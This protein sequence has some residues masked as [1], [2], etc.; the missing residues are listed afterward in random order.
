MNFIAYV[1]Q[2]DFGGGNFSVCAEVS[3]SKSETRERVSM[4]GESPTF[5]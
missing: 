4:A 2:F 1:L 5:L 3:D